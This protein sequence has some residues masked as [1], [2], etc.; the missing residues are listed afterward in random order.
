MVRHVCTSCCVV[1]VFLPVLFSAYMCAPETADKSVQSSAPAVPTDV[2]TPLTVSCC[3]FPWRPE[4]L[5]A[6]SV[7]LPRMVGVWHR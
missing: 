7:S 2:V 4:V 3:V 5:D 1:F 6:F